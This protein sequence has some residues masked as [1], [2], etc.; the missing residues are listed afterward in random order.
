LDLCLHLLRRD[1]GA[2]IA[3]KVARRLVLPAHRQGGQA[4]YVERPVA[5]ERGGGSRLGALLDEIRRTLDQDWP[6][7][8]MAEFAALSL[9]ALHR[10]FQETTAF[11]P[12]DWLTRERVARAQELLETTELPIEDVAASSGFGSAA[13]L[14][15]HFRAGLGTSPAA[16]RG[17]FGQAAT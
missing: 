8:R 11:S 7:A 5:P 9:R 2:E 14:R 1:F 10:R 16:Y 4:Q 6:N 12:G 15:H 3:N 13:T 17:R